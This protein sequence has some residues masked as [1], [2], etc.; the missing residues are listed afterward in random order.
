[1]LRSVGPWSI[2]LNKEQSL[3]NC[4]CDEIKRSQHFIYIENQYFIG[5]PSTPGG[6]PNA[7]LQR[8]VLAYQ[9]NRK[10]RVI[11]VLP[12]HP[13]GDFV[14]NMNPRFVLSYQQRTMYK[15]SQSLIQEFKQMCP[16]E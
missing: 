4:W 12:Q 1:M 15:G 7:I 9:Q 2:G 5:T 10:F 14:N 6:I 13:D 3:M 16:N 11:V 8:L